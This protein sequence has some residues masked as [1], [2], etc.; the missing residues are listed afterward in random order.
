MD[1]RSY[2]L[3]K[4]G[5]GWF[6]RNIDALESRKVFPDID[7]VS[8][9]LHPEAIPNHIKFLEIGCG[10]GHRTRALASMV[11]GEGWGIDP[12]KKAIRFARSQEN[13]RQDRKFCPLNYIRG[14]AESLDFQ[15]KYFDFIYFAFC[16]YLIDRSLLT[17][18]RD[19]A[20]RVLKNGGKLA[21]LDFDSSTK[22]VKGNKNSGSLATFRDTHEELFIQLGYDIV[23]KLSLMSDST[24]GF[25]QDESS[26]VALHLLNKPLNKS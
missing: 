16:F 8:Q 14:T 13:S 7:L 15:D 6:E 20:D 26:R 19:E 18:V 23:A 21:I 9:Y 4:G 22:V 10:P 5:D 12:S 1:L 11:N 25:S 2:F 3:N 24:I 17:K